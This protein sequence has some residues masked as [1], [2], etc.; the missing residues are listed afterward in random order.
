MKL[1]SL[2]VNGLIQWPL[3]NGGHIRRWN[4]LQGLLKAG[5][6][7]ALVFC[8]PDEQDSFDAFAGCRKVFRADGRY[9][10][11]SPN[12]HQLYASTIGRGWLVLGRRYPLQY[13]AHHLGKLRASLRQLVDFTQYDAVWFGRS[14]VAVAVG[15]LGNVPTILDGDDFE[16]VR[17]WLLLRNSPWYGA[18]AWNYL[19]LLKLWWLERSFPRRFTRVVRCSEEDRRRHSAPNVVVIPNGTQVPAEP[20]VRMPR[21]RLLF[22]GLLGY[23]PNSQGLEWFFR[24]VWPHVRREVPQAEIDVVG[25]EPPEAIWQ[26][27]GSDGIHVHGFVEDLTP[28]YAQA[29]AAVVPLLAG[30]GTRLKIVEAIAREVPVVSTR[31]GAFGLE[32]AEPHG[33][34]LA[35][36]PEAFAQRCIA[37]L[38]CP[39]QAIAAVQAGRALVRARYDWQVIQQQ[40]ADL[41]REVA[42]QPRADASRSQAPSEQARAAVHA[43]DAV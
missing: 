12:F 9:L 29:A 34:F 11:P 36:A 2:F 6:T 15:P 39:Q 20:P 18:K 1:R 23:A 14:D 30:G 41:V 4:M 43:Q 35:D 3:T 24:H 28:L 13:T 16:Y 17:E 21:Q 37:L 33:V 19:D 10:L 38:R 32:L 8:L 31:L 40:V 25:K 27:S 26:R 42:R 5:Q 22:V 7:D